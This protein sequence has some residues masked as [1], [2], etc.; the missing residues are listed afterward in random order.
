MLRQRAGEI[1]EVGATQCVET[2]SHRGL[3]DVAFLVSGRL[4]HVGGTPGST[5]AAGSHITV[6]DWKIEPSP[7]R[8]VCSFIRTWE[9][10]EC[11]RNI[12]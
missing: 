9:Y 10:I 5:A 11:P 4:T 12:A 6:I 3:L 1:A 2:G 7:T 8:R